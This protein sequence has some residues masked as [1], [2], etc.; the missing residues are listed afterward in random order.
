MLR[1]FGTKPASSMFRTISAS[2]MQYS[3]PAARTTFSSIITLPMS[4]AP[5][6]RLSWPTLPPCVTHDACRLSKLSRTMRERARVRR[7]SMPVASTPASS[8]LSG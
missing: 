2:S 1:R 8:V 3:A 4:L 7:Y 5:K 6:A